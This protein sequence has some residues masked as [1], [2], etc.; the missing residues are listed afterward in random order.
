MRL[1]FT[2]CLILLTNIILEAQIQQVPLGNNIQV[3]K[4]AK[5]QVYQKAKPRSEKGAALP[6][7]DDFAY[8]GP[9]PDANLWLNRDVFINNTLANRPVSI[10]V[11]TFD[12][13][14]A[15]GSPYGGFDSADT[16]TSIG[17]DMSG[18]ATKYMS[19]YIQPKGFG[20]VP[21]PGDKLVL[22][23]KNAAGDW[24]EMKSHEVTIDES[25]FPIDSIPTFQYVG[26]IEINDAQFFHEDFQFRF[27]NYALRNGAVDMWHLDYVRLE[28][29]PI[30][31]ITGDLAFTSLPSNILLDYSSAPWIHV[32]EVITN[33]PQLVLTEVDLEI[34]N[35]SNGSISSDE[36]LLLVNGIDGGEM[37]RFKRQDLDLD[38]KNFQVGLNSFTN[39]I[40]GE[41]RSAFRNEFKNSDKIQ[42]KVDYSFA[43]N[44]AEPVGMQRNNMVSRV[45]NLDD[46]YAYDDNSAES[47]IIMGTGGQ[48]AVKFTN[49]KED[50]LQAIRMHIPRIVGDISQLNF[51]LKV[52]LN[53]LN[54]EPV[55]ER[56]FTKPIFVD[57]FRDSLQAFTTY[58]FKDPITGES[59]P[60]PLP[61]GDFYI[62]WEQVTPCGNVNC[63][64]VGLDRNTPSAT[65]NTFV[66]PEGNWGHI[67]DFFTGDL[68]VSFMGALMLR[69]VVGSEPPRESE[70][71]LSTS[72]LELGQ[73]MNI[74]PNP[75]EGL[76]NIQ[77][78]EGNYENFE[79]QVFNTMG[80]QVQ[81]QTLTNQL[82]L[83]KE[84]PG[85][86]ILQIIDKETL[87][88]G[89]YKLV[90]Y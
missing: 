22:E 40:K 2:S 8:E 14:D 85:I 81:Q 33:T 5:E 60:V 78:F 29:M 64:P 23:F 9:Y 32:R 52:W 50:L 27:R 42:V 25:V 16:L 18:A 72:N 13:L 35:H 34:F 1:L 24:I 3:A 17:I 88:A 49:Y 59:T 63:L 36:G 83:S 68:P 77:L 65:V 70:E 58:V 75:S 90:V 43:Q 47:A 20:D 89:N 66:N 57:E 37:L 45:F 54:S 53:D 39:P 51:T 73:L 80:Q 56:E 7:F 79:I 82:D 74:F 12:G 38:Q 55:Y 28:A 71:A 15:T 44:N 11:A 30:N 48:V 21:G 41:Y 4:A 86:Y 62:G 84:V 87:A 26:P 6:F 67:S 61:V 19:Y 31:Q 76:V 10:G 69:P 46:F